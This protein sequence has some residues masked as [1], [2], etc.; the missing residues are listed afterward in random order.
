M[1]Y[2]HYTDTNNNKF[3]KI[4]MIESICISVVSVLDSDTS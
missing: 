1:K 3:K 2:G 4:E